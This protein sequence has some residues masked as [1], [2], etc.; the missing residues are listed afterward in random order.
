MSADVNP[1][2]DDFSDLPSTN[3]LAVLALLATAPMTAYGLAEQLERALGYYW[4]ISRRLL[5]GEPQR[6]AA[7]GLV[8][9]VPPEPGSRAKRR[10]SATPEG[11]AVLRRWLERDVA[12]TELASEIGLRVIFADHGDRE[13][14]RRQLLVR[15]GQ[16]VAQLRTG[17]ELMDGYLR[18]DGP[19]P[20]RLHIVSATAAML[21][22][23]LKGEIRA[24]DAMVDVVDSWRTTT[25]PAPRR[26][27]RQLRAV[28]D[29]TAAELARLEGLEHIARE[30]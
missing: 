2:E 22:E 20:G 8:E 4:T 23:Q 17:L 3:A 16:L 15:R 18:G 9:E 29:E 7:R 28:R 11:R 21:W 27:L 5:L 30:D 24:V 25:T 13:V 14:L 10:W 6:L 1:R 12:P 26:D 19:F